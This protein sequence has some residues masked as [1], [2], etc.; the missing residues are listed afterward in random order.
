MTRQEC[1]GGVQNPKAKEGDY[2]EAVDWMP[3]CR[4]DNK[5]GIYNNNSL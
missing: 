4:Q 5:I 1:G 3:T 2:E